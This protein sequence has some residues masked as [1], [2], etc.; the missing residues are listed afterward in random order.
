MTEEEF[1]DLKPGDYVL[2]DWCD[3]EITPLQVLEQ[4]LP[5]VNGRPFCVLAEGA[6]TYKGQ[7]CSLS[8]IV[9]LGCACRM[10]KATLAEITIAV[11]KGGKE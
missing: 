4:E 8:G 6:R 5:W 10:Q 11:L 3:G 9:R 1:R 2:Y 7:S